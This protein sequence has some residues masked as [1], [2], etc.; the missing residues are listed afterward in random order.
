MVR[1][2]VIDSADGIGFLYELLLNLLSFELRKAQLILVK[3]PFDI[4]SCEHKLEIVFLFL[5]LNVYRTIF[6]EAAEFVFPVFA[7]LFVYSRVS[8]H[9][10]TQ[11]TFCSS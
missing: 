1:C 8:T 6:G 3:S 2:L 11:E 5:D 10:E 7:D 9:V 4:L